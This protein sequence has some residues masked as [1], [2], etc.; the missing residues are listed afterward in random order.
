MRTPAVEGTDYCHRC[1]SA[2]FR[3][4]V[5]C[6][7]CGVALGQ[8]LEI[9]DRPS[10]DYRKGISPA[11]VPWN[12][13]LACLLTVLLPGLPQMMFGQVLKGIAILVAVAIAWG[14]TEHALVPVAWGLAA[15]DAYRIAAKLKDGLHV[16]Y[17]EF[18]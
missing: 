8:A 17:W 10:A 16:G 9:P 6:V 13:L 4:A 3:D 15:V 14:S 1:G 18:F 11:A 7:S 2:T 12:P 5:V